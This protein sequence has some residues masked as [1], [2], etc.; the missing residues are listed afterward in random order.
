MDGQAPHVGLAGAHRVEEGGA[1]AVAGGQEQPR[2]LVHRD[3]RYWGNS[4]IL[5]VDY[6]V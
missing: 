4:P 2:E 6:Q 5:P 3:G 1:V